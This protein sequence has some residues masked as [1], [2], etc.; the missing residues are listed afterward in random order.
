MS[1]QQGIFK[2]GK[3]KWV[4]DWVTQL[5]FQKCFA[6]CEIV[7]SSQSEDNSG[8]LYVVEPISALFTP[9]FVFA[10][11]NIRMSNGNINSAIS[12]H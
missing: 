5:V 4:L 1:S 12:V 6:D 8:D 10:Y 7:L 3:D 2:S 11:T 9:N